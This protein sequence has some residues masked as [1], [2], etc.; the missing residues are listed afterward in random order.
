MWPVDVDRIDLEDVVV[1][2]VRDVHL[3]LHVGIVGR[4]RQ[5]VGVDEP[6]QVIPVFAVPHGDRPP[7]R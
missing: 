4:I 2:K 7:L 1:D 3:A 6:Q 5:V